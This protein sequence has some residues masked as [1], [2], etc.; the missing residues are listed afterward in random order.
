M[1]VGI[2]REAQLHTST[3]VI[4]SNAKPSYQWRFPPQLAGRFLKPM[5]RIEMNK[6]VTATYESADSLRNVV[7]ELLGIGF[8]QD[9][10]YAEK[11]KNQIKV[12]TPVDGESVIVELLQRHHPKTL[13]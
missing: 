1:E 11:D 6:T 2:Q 3:G 12:I 8:P 10:F 4:P 9:K 13:H 7:D 5:R